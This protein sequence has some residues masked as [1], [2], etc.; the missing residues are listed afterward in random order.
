MLAPPRLDPRTSFVVFLAEGLRACYARSMLARIGLLAL[1][2]ASSPS[3]CEKVFGDGR[4]DAHNPG[5]DLG[6]YDVTANVT[7]N[8]CGNGALGQ[9]ASW[10]FDVRL[11]RDTAGGVL[12]WNNGQAA[13]AGTLDADDVS[14]GFDTSVIQN[15]RDPN[16]VGPPPCS[17][18][19]ADHAEGKLNAATD[20]VASFTGKLSYT[21]AATAGSNC[22]DLVEESET[23]VV[24]ALPCTMS[25]TMTGKSASAE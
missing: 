15:M 9:Q 13:I 25:Y 8:T 22:A 24:L 11:S 5:T 6:S 3:G 19:R 4:Q 16:V 2:A 10:S 7:S 1:V 12:Y 18:A 14:F 17:I 21:F 20:P 23:P